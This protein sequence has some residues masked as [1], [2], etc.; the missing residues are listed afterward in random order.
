MAKLSVPEA[1]EKLER[2][3]LGH[4]AT[5]RAD[6]R[7]HVVPIV[8]ASIGDSL[9]TMV[10]HKPKTTQHLQRLE[11][12]ESN[13]WVSVV[14]DEWSE[15]WEQLWWVRVDGQAFVHRDDDVW[16]EARMAMVAKYAQYRE[17]APEGPAI[18]ITI[19]R[20]VAWSGSR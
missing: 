6:G 4:L 2:S 8:Y 11:N 19:D 1:H 12:I 15:D 10:D 18:V 14:V 9:V 7:P 5:V 16:R 17:K 20:I 13:P 3:R